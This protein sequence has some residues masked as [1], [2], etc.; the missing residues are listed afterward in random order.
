[1]QNAKRG[2][3]VKV[4]YTGKF[5]TGRVFDRTKNSMPLVFQIGDGKVVPEFENEVIGMRV[6]GKKTVTIAAEKAFGLR[7]ER[8][9]FDIK[10]SEFPCQIEIFLGKRIN[11]QL[12]NAQTISAKIVSVDDKS[13]RVDANHPL[14]DETLIFDIELLEIL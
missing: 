13:V 6:G 8:L 2:D 7:H 3:K 1:M 5:L 14:A 4:H 9:I 12:P 10:K 11:V